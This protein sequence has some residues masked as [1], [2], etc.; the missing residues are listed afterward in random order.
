M[1]AGYRQA[2][3]FAQILKPR[4]IDSL[5]GLGDRV[6]CPVVGRPAEP[7]PK[8]GRQNIP[9]DCETQLQCA[10]AAV[11][12]FACIE[13]PLTGLSGQQGWIEP[14]YVPQNRIGRCANRGGR[15]GKGN[16]Q[17][18]KAARGNLR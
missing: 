3:D 8:M 17:R 7:S 15:P 16:D 10:L 2:A 6:N 11:A 18:P 4:R 1:V 13:H 12:R 9:V 5:S 14:G